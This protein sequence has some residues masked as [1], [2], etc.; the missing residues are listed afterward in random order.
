MF[1]QIKSSAFHLGQ[2]KWPSKRQSVLCTR[3]I[4]KMVTKKI[5][6]LCFFIHRC[7]DLDFKGRK[8]RR[9]SLE[10]NKAFHNI[11]AYELRQTDLTLKPLPTSQ[12]TLCT[13]AH[14]QT[15]AQSHFSIPQ[16]YLRV[17]K[18]PMAIS[19]RNATTS[20]FGP[21]NTEI[22]CHRH[23]QTSPALDTCHMR[24]CSLHS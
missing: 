23:C 21:Y 11:Y 12:H 3:T 13:L 5:K 8:W 16:S 6:K 10:L 24:Q 14:S 2:F 19:W 7:H 1:P 4:V 20:K 9:V 17:S 22:W 15:P 18:S